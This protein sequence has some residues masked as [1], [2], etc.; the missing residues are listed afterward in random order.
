[1][2]WQLKRVG[3]LPLSMW[4]GEEIEFG[5]PYKGPEETYAVDLLEALQA[6]VFGPPISAPIFLKNSRGGFTQFL[7]NGGRAYGDI[8]TRP[9]TYD[10]FEVTTPECR[11][12]YE[13]T[14]YDKAA[15]LIA[16]IASEQ[17]YKLSNIKVH[18][19][20]ASL[21][22]AKTDDGSVR[23]STRGIHE[24]YLVDRASVIPK[25][26]LLIPYL[27][28]RQ[29]F[30]GAG[31]YYRNRFVISPRQLFIKNLYA[32]KIFDEWPM[33]C[34][35]DEP[36]A[37]RRF[38]RLHVVNCDGARLQ[39]TTFLRNSITSY[40][41]KGIE[42]GT[43]TK[44]PRV[45]NPVQSAKL[46]ATNPDGDWKVEVEGGGE[47]GAVELL[48]SYYLPAIEEL[49]QGEGADEVDELALSEFKRALDKVGSGL[50]EDVANSIEWVA[51]LMVIERGFDDYF[52]YEGD[53]EEG[54]VA[55]DYQ[56]AAVTEDLFEELERELSFKRLFDDSRIR[57]AVANPPPNSRAEA[58]VRLA[59]MFK[60]GLDEVGW[61]SMAIKGRSIFMLEMD[62]WGE[63][64]VRELAERIRRTILAVV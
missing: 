4:Q 62:G 54:R 26:D 44:A 25:L 3:H 58:R 42:S 57:W 19:Y 15:E 64:K 23:Y 2:L 45:V 8:G 46:I 32:E 53:P 9:G 6:Y 41:L 47:V 22:R 18:C 50:L 61:S 49:L 1:M 43:L 48:S 38:Y 29:I 31:G 16:R 30:C 10:I 59:D 52:E 17:L 27:V 33:V 35:R 37:E 14:L 40:V 12:A 11:N 24:V 21:T 56:Y 60:D 13:L 51:K 63:V 28:V 34:L 39:M 36:H 7:R 55:A 5:V 20:K